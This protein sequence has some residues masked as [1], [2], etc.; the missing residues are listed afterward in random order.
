MAKSWFSHDVAQILCGQMLRLIK[1]FLSIIDDRPARN[2]VNRL[3]DECLDGRM[4]VLP[5][6]LGQD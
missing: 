3:L 2:E 1:V 6:S 4:Y 5:G